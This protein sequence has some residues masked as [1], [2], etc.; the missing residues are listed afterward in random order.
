MATVLAKPGDSVDFVL[1]L[2][3]GV[4]VRDEK[5]IEDKRE[6]FP[7]KSF[8][9]GGF[10]FVQR[11]F[12]KV[13][14][15]L[16]LHWFLAHVL[17]VPASACTYNATTQAWVYNHAVAADRK[18]PC[19]QTNAIW[20]CPPPLAPLQT[21]RYDLR[22]RAVPSPAPSLITP[23]GWAMGGECPAVPPPQN[24]SSCMWLFVLSEQRCCGHS[25][26]KVFVWIFA[27]LTLCFCLRVFWFVQPSIGLRH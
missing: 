20:A 17:L 8:S 22:S 5:S 25:A 23:V 11:T 16:R 15:S 24:P 27:V 26:D 19:A 6:G 12:R 4:V 1:L 9:D 7:G 2:W 10:A 3:G 13:W 21:L 18:S 14:F